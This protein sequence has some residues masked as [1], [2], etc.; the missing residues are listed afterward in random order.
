MHT[1]ILIMR[2][3]SDKPQRSDVSQST[4]PVYLKAVMVMRNKERLRRSHSQE[5]PGEHKDQHN[6]ISPEQGSGAER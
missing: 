2:E 6:E 5:E 4:W 3:T 1:P